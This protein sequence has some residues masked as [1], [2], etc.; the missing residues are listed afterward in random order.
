MYGH[1]PA[2]RADA[3]TG[4]VGHD[5]LPHFLRSKANLLV[6]I[7]LLLV[8]GLRLVA[9]SGWTFVRVAIRRSFFRSLLDL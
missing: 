4:E 2:P 1:Y 6:Q 5:R 8:A 3:A 7:K 9:P